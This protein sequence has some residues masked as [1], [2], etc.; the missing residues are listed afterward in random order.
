MTKTYKHKTLPC[1]AMRHEDENTVVSMVQVNLFNK[2]IIRPVKDIE[3][4]SDRI[5]VV[6]KD[7]IL[8]TIDEYKELSNRVWRVPEEDFEKIL[9]KN[10]PQVKK[11]TREDVEE[12]VWWDRPVAYIS[13]RDFLKTHNLLSSDE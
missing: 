12:F 2:S 5:E 8:K 9:R 10:A 4:S 3:N 7:W 1:V 13:I 11:F 6:E